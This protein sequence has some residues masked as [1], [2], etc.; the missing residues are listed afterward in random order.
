MQF[1]HRAALS[2]P[3]VIVAAVALTA[4]STVTRVTSSPERALKLSS[5]VEAPLVV[6][7]PPGLLPLRY[8]DADNDYFI[9]GQAYTK[10]VF[11]KLVAVPGGGVCVTQEMPHKVGVFIAAGSCDFHIGEQPSYMIIT[12]PPRSVEP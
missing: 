11:G 5:V 6:T 8:Q 2:A 1:S 7:V 3:I 10:S 9:S 12:V 4:C